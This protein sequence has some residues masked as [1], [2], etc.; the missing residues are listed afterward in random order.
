MTS[1]SV[2]VSRGQSLMIFGIP[3]TY[4]VSALPESRTAYVLSEPNSATYER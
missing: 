3:S 4:A 2:I 1:S